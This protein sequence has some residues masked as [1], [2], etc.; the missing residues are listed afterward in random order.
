MDL[1]RKL[2]KRVTR[3][4]GQTL[5]RYFKERMPAKIKKEL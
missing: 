5:Q 4:Q 1:Q 2:R 3:G